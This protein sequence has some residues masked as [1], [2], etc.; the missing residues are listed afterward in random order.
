MTEQSVQTHPQDVVPRSEFNARVEALQKEFGAQLRGITSAN[1]KMM[2][3]Q[4]QE[5][6]AEAEAGK[7]Y[8]L[9]LEDRGQRRA[10]LENVE[11]RERQRLLAL[12]QVEKA[13]AEDKQPVPAAAPEA[14]ARAEAWLEQNS[15]L[16]DNPRLMRMA[17]QIE[18]PN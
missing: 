8:A 13:A 14:K 15:W 10:A 6:M 5:I 1:S 2:D 9:E 16:R 18:I 3:L 7:S 4:R 12:N 11:K 17:G